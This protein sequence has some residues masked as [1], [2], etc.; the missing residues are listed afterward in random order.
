[1]RVERRDSIS[2]TE[3]VRRL[4]SVGDVVTMKHKEDGAEIVFNYPDGRTEELLIL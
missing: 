1:M 3:A 2:L 4:L